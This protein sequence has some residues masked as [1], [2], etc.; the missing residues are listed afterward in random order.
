MPRER[1][2]IYGREEKT[3][4][5]GGAIAVVIVLVLII[6]VLFAMLQGG[7][8]VISDADN[9]LAQSEIAAKGITKES[10]TFDGVIEANTGAGY[11][12][13]PISG[14]GR[15]DSENRR[16]SFKVNLEAPKIDGQVAD[17]DAL[18]IESY[19]VDKTVYTNFGGS[20]SKYEAGD[21]L[22][23]E[24]HITQKL[25]DLAKNFDLSLTEKSMVNGKMAYK[26]VV[27]PTME[28]LVGLMAT[29]DPGILER[30]GVTNFDNVGDGVKEIEM[31]IWISE[32]DYLPIKTDFT[33]SAETNTINP[34][35]SG[36]LKTEVLMEF[37]LNF[38]Y[39]TPFNIVLPSAASSAV[40]L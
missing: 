5:K 9:L 30:V 24:A 19:V 2:S 8:P 16:M 25:I 32:K 15:I 22:W 13:I 12:G 27:N 7:G 40:E 38:D 1:P 34:A 20:W 17:T 10:F 21:R 6:G 28:E 35:G 26:L 29:M 33:L 18:V 31:V 37:T 3:S 36:V 14:D 11:F 4:G 23:G 39:T